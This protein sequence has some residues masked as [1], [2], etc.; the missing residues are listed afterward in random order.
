MS[1]LIDVDLFDYYQ[2][3]LIWLWYV[4]GVFVECYLKVVWCL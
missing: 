2:C 4:G 1:D 3:E